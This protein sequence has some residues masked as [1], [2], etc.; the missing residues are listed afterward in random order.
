MIKIALL[1]AALQSVS[2]VDERSTSASIQITLTL[3]P[4]MLA[5]VDL[6]Q[7]DEAVAGIYRLEAQQVM[8]HVKNPN[9][10]VQK[11]LIIDD[12]GVLDNERIEV[13]FNDKIE[14]NLPPLV[15]AMR[16]PANMTDKEVMTACLAERKARGTSIAKK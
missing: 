13:A 12:F 4:A 2:S 16:W 1:I 10:K 15:V 11:Y 8:V 6:V 9:N 14:I 3:E 5:N 7:V